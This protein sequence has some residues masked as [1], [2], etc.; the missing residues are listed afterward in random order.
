[1][2]LRFWLLSC[3][4]RRR[5]D[6]PLIAACPRF[7]G[8]ADRPEGCFSTLS[9]GTDDLVLVLRGGLP[10]APAKTPGTPPIQGRIKTVQ[11]ETETPPQR[12]F[13]CLESLLSFALL[14]NPKLLVP[15]LTPAASHTQQHR[16]LG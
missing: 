3:R 6:A 9:D 8:N 5:D 12:R 16:V 11:L 15:F 7:R 1:V 4:C 10:P 13:R 2:L 14:G